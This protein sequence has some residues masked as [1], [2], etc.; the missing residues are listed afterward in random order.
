MS[1][2]SKLTNEQILG[3]LSAAWYNVSEPTHWAHETSRT[4]TALRVL[5]QANKITGAAA[6]TYL[7]RKL[8]VN[9]RGRLAASGGL[10]LG[11]AVALG[12]HSWELIQ[13]TLKNALGI[14]SN[15]IKQSAAHDLGLGVA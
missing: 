6:G 9:R 5:G 11:T 15:F 7:G 12:R 3:R 2:M 4:S 14:V 13:D 8:V 1:N 10:A